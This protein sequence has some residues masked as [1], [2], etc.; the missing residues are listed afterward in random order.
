MTLIFNLSI[1]AIKNAYEDFLRHR[2]DKEINERISWI[3]DQTEFLPIQWQNIQGGQIIKIESENQFPADVILVN[4]SSKTGDCLIET[5][6]LDGETSLK[7]RKIVSFDNIEYIET[8]PP[9]TSLNQ[10]S[11]IIKNQNKEISVSLNSFVPRGCILKKTN[12]VFGL[13]VYTG[14]ETKISLNSQK[15]Q[16]KYAEI[17][18]ILD[19]IIGILLLITIAVCLIG[20]LSS[21]FFNQNHLS[22]KYL[23]LQELSTFDNILQFFTWMLLV[24]MIVP[25]AV[26]S[27]LDV[28]RFF[29]SVSINNDPILKRKVKCRNSELVSTI[30]RVTHIF[31]DKTGTLTKNK[32]IFQ[33]FGLNSKQFS[34]EPNHPK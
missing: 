17:D 22:E 26:Y 11:A 9:S 10:F 18:R 25:L 16:V 3:F 20:A 30:G 7:V 6:A 21:Y 33:T 4:S 19:K 32:M 13:V 8:I 12:F 31:S 27:S 2:S 14:D 15:P 34:H 29:L 1:T 23:G 28:V 24:N 5:S